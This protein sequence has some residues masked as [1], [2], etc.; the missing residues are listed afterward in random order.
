MRRSISGTTG[1]ATWRCVAGV[2]ARAGALCVTGRTARGRNARTR[3]RQGASG[4]AI[5]AA[6]ARAANPGVILPGSRRAGAS[7]ASGLVVAVSGPTRIVRPRL[8]A[9]GGTRTRTVHGSSK[10]SPVTTAL[11]VAFR[12]PAWTGRRRRGL[13]RAGLPIIAA[14]TNASTRAVLV[15][16]AA[17]RPSFRQAQAVT[18]AG[19]ATAPLPGGAARAVVSISG[20]A[21]RIGLVC[22]VRVRFAGAGACKDA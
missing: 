4:T 13:G 7:L 6:P 17:R 8:G 9:L 3:R 21:R 12:R 10:A 19:M 14:S 22:P 18:A 1:L 15:G 16:R 11:G 5:E 2:G 20:L